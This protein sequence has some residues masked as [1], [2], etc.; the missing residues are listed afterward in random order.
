M[1]QVIA[2]QPG[3]VKVSELSTVLPETVPVVSDAVPGFD[4]TVFGEFTANSGVPP[5]EDSDHIPTNAYAVCA[6]VLR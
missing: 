6:S 5:A 3:K 1:V 2:P 4:V